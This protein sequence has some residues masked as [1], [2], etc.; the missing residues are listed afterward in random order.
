MY[1]FGQMVVNNWNLRLRRFYE[2]EDFLFRVGA[3]I[4]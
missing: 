4:S 3:Q 1:F 2:S